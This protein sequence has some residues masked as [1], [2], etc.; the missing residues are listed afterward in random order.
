MSRQL[1]L[2]PRF[3]LRGFFRAVLQIWNGGGP[4]HR[5]AT[6]A[7]QAVTGVGLCLHVN[8]RAKNFLRLERAV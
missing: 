1:G 7:I 4:G 6:V 5:D 8:E 3:R 2:K